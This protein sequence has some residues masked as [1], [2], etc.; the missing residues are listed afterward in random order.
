M[1]SCTSATSNNSRWPTCMAPAGV[2]SLHAAAEGRPARTAYEESSSEEDIG[3]IA[4]D[5]VV[6]VV[7]R[8]LGEAS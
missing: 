1:L 2:G 5:D 4:A 3:F 6:G 8:R 7:R